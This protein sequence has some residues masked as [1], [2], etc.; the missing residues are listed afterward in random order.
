MIEVTKLTMAV[1]QLED[2]LKAYFG[3]RYHSAIVLAGAAEQLFAGYVLKQQM[4]PAWS[5]TRRTITKI[6]NGLHYR[7]TGEPGKTTEKDI[8]DL[9]NH[10]Y[11]HSKHAG[12]KDH[13]VRMNPKFEAREL[14]DRVISNY[15]MLF[16]CGAYDLPDIPLFH[17][18]LQE[19]I[20][21]MRL[22]EDAREILSPVSANGEA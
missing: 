22:E 14:L 20:D 3:G 7:Q 8:G 16:G 13:V 11:N 15:D 1:E 2:S 21:E 5:Q 12:T 17:D 9:L 18:F 10:A 6:A 19:P 4:E